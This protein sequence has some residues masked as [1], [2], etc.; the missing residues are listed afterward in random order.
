M[1][2]LH[3]LN[4]DVCMSVGA[5]NKITALSETLVPAVGKYISQCLSNSLCMCIPRSLF[6][7]HSHKH[8]EI[9]FTCIHKHTLSPPP[10]HTL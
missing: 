1:F 5:F 9:P 4:V 6:L 10:S 3:R 7:F 8:T 2:E